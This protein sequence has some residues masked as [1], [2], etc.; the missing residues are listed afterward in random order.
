MRIN[1]NLGRIP[2]MLLI[3]HDGE[4]SPFFYWKNPRK[5]KQSIKYIIGIMNRSI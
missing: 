2:K 5:Y 1:F 4:K 3:F